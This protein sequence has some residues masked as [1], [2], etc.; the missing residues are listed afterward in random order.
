MSEFVKG[1]CRLAVVPMYVKPGHDQALGS[2][3]LFGEHYAIKNSFK[4]W[5]EI[6]LAFDSSKGWIQASQHTP[7][8]DAYYDQ[9]N[10]SDYKVCTDVSGSIF[11]QKKYVNIVLGSILPISSNE[12][13]KMEEQVAYNGSSKSLSQRREFEFLLEV[14]NQYRH[15]PFR[16]G[17]KTPFG[18]DS[19]GFVQQVFKICGYRLPRTAEEQV[20][21][22]IHVSLSEVGIGDLVFTGNKKIN[23][24]ISLGEGHFVGV[25]GGSV[26]KIANLKVEGDS[27]KSRSVFKKNVSARM[28]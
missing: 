16:P 22:A 18:I 12:L 23:V 14:I 15:T 26:E 21:G 28:I 7:I 6:E 3:L 25:I 2:E 9:I 10:A 17:G 13:F 1:I 8:S 19:G 5:L 11:F 4:D 20:K 27:L 24:L